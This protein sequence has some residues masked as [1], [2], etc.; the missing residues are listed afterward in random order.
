MTGLRD[1]QREAAAALWDGWLSGQQR[2]AVVLPTGSGKTRIMAA[3]ACE[4]V[5]AGER[6]LILVHR[7]ELAQQTARTL[8]QVDASVV[9]GIV[10]AERN[11]VGARVVVASIQTLARGRR[12]EQLLARGK[13]GMVLADEIHL[14][15]ADSWQRVLAD[16]GCWRPDGPKLGGFTATF[17]RAD[18]RGLGDVWQD[19]VYTKGI[20]WFIERGYLVPPRGHAVTTD[21]DLDRLKRTGGDYDEKEMG[22]RLA[23]ET[24][25][26]AIID[27]WTSHAGDRLGVLFAPT[28]AAAEF[29]A[30]GLTAAGVPTRGV[31]GATPRTERA[32]IYRQHKDGDV[33]I[34]ASCTALAEGWDAPWTSCAV[35]AR[36]TLHPGL[37]IQQIGR[38]LR[39]WPGKSDALVIDVAG[40][41]RQHSLHAVIELEET[42]RRATMDLPEVETK[43]EEEDGGIAPDDGYRGPVAFEEVDLFAG[44]D[45]KWHTTSGGVLFVATSSSLIF[46]NEHDGAWRV[47]ECPKNSVAQ[48]KWL[49]EGLASDE[50]L[51]WASEYAIEKDPTVGSKS[52]S[53]RKKGGAPSAA[54]VDFAQKLGIDTAGMTKTRLSDAITE[55]VASRTLARFGRTMASA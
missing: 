20:R 29:F 7:D 16:V 49:V 35:L 51:N 13:F 2:L 24:T 54:Q 41:T 44:T 43:E 38:V 40:A 12:L 14:S 55:R 22:A 45:A 8:R 42:K 5:A 9:P 47:G 39:P 1:Y 27:A 25:R 19:V 17:S 15:A 34:I 37:F 21:V 31:F 4:R 26:D 28:V 53:W 46:L 52:A 30:E 10:K 33:R 18:S 32:E 6:V 36:P 48:G 50:A 11:E 3:L 23:T